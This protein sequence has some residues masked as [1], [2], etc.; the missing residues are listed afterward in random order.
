MQLKVDVA[1]THGE[2]VSCKR[3]LA[4]AVERERHMSQQVEYLEQRVACSP[5]PSAGWSVPSVAASMSAAAAAMPSTVGRF[6]H[7]LQTPPPAVV[8]DDEV[9]DEETE[10]EN[11]ESESWDEEEDDDEGE[12]Q[13]GHAGTATPVA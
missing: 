9:E 7:V 10:S 3:A 4:R 5:A 11:E 12:E 8:M 6:G 1:E 13:G 2:L